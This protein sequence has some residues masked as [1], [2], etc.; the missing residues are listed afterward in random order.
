MAQELAELVLVALAL[1][2]VVVVVERVHVV[3][4]GPDV[5]EQV[6]VEPALADIAV[7]DVAAHTAVVEAKKT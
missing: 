7:D 1:D 5:V 6:R 4:R 2:A 3:G